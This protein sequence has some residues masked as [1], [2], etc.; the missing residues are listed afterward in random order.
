MKKGYLMLLSLLVCSFIATGYSE[1]REIET[2]S[3]QV[4]DKDVV[5][6][7]NDLQVTVLPVADFSAELPI[8]LVIESPYLGKRTPNK[9]TVSEKLAAGF[10]IS[11]R[12]PPDKGKIQRF[13]KRKKTR[14]KSLVFLCLCIFSLLNISYFF[15]YNIKAVSLFTNVHA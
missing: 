8:E 9:S 7:S 15:S 14:S 4:V 13:K 5:I 3:I 2:P 10:F 1:S 12:P 11:V 6:E